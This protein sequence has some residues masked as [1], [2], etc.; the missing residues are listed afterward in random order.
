MYRKAN[1]LQ[2]ELQTNRK[3]ESIVEDIRSYKKLLHFLQDEEIHISFYFSALI[4]RQFIMI[5]T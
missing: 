3:T 1:G 2:T 5:N 4:K